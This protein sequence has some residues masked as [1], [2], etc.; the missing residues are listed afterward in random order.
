M[1][2]PAPRVVRSTSSTARIAVEWGEACGSRTISAPPTSSTRSSGSKAPRFTSRSYSRRLQCF[3]RARLI[4][5][6]LKPACRGRQC[7]AAGTPPGT[8]NSVVLLDVVLTVNRPRS[9][10]FRPAPVRADTLA[11]EKRHTPPSPRPLP[12]GE[13]ERLGLLQQLGLDREGADALARERID[14]VAH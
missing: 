7:L 2:Q 11:N 9:G 6:R 12:S 14:G 13:R 8:A 1:S 5:D 4:D 10:M 3:V